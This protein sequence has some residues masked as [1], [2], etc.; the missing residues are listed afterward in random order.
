MKRID[1]ACKL[2]SPLV[3]AGVLTQL[4]TGACSLVMAAWCVV[5]FVSELYLVRRIWFQSPVLWTPR[6]IHHGKDHQQQEDSEEGAA[7]R[8][9]SESLARKR[10][11]SVL[12]SQ[13]TSN[14]A[15]E[16]LHQEEN[17]GLLRPSTHIQ[18]SATRQRKVNFLQKIYQSFREYSLHVVFLGKLKTGEPMKEPWQSISA[19]NT[20][21]SY[22]IRM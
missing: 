15:H 6:S 10:T 18:G 7:D 19:I 21:S 11:R 17:R 9:G 16:E 3:F 2:V 13:S 12:S 14:S 1:L 4:S 8:V 20:H 22:L 5:S